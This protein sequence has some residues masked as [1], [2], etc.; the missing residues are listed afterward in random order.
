[1]LV[2]QHGSH[3]QWN[4][5][6][7]SHSFSESVT[8]QFN[9]DNITFHILNRHSTIL[10]I[11]V[12]LF[13]KVLYL[14]YKKIVFKFDEWE[15]WKVRKGSIQHRSVFFG[16]TFEPEF[17]PLSTPQTS[18]TETIVRQNHLLVHFDEKKSEWVWF[19]CHRRP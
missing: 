8:A 2:I 11:V 13:R 14:H 18:T 6:N 16:D 19:W 10:K 9:I 5:F 7:W 1:L 17:R 4:R 15:M 3:F 12:V